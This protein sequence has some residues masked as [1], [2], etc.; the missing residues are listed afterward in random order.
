LSRR[1]I[2]TAEKRAPSGPLTKLPRSF[3]SAVEVDSRDDLIEILPAQEDMDEF[4]ALVK[5]YTDTISAKEAS[6]VETLSYQHLE[7]ELADVEK[8]Y[9][10]PGG[11]M[12]LLRVN[13]KPA[14]CVALTGHDE[15]CEM[16]RLYF[17]PADRGRG[18]SRLLCERVIE[19]A[20]SIGYTY[21][22]LD[23][24]PFMRNA[25]HLYEKLGFEYIDKY[26]HNP[27]EDA[28]FMQLSLR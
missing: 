24:F 27:A 4:I 1:F 19:D 5:E 8:K 21:M 10:R 16:K 17:R 13:R 18:L 26:N 28:I 2:L 7:E 6:V 14:G 22:H 15:C 12:Y 11:R 20:R 23:T 9:G 3:G 25:L